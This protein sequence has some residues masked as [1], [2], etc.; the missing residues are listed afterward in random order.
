MNFSCISIMCIYWIRQSLY[1]ANIISFG[2]MNATALDLLIRLA[3]GTCCSL[4]ETL[5]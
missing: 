3:F 2:Y 1:N 5:W 4:P